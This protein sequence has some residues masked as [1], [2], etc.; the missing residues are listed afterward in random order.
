M[1]N[2]QRVDISVWYLGVMAAASPFESPGTP[3]VLPRGAHGLDREVVMASQRGRL[4][5][6]LVDEVADQG[7]YAVTIADIVK[8]AGTAKRTFYEHFE[9]KDDCYRQAFEAGSTVII[10]EIVK[11]ADAEPDPINRIEVGVRAYLQ[12]LLDLPNFARLYLSSAG[13]SDPEIAKSW[14]TWISLLADGMV[15]WRSESR[16]KHPEMPPL[17]QP[18]AIAG[19]SGLN[20]VVRIEL[21]A[22]GTDGIRARTDEFV[23]LG[24]SLL[25][26]RLPEVD[27]GE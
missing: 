18:Q 9:D 17:S 15:A 13:S 16:E 26:A 14:I 22:N 12:A 24:I 19:I 11:A 27:A 8:R 2:Y 5:T 1:D 21:F 20:E 7:F 25:T 10:S 23:A 3:D 4:L 6:A